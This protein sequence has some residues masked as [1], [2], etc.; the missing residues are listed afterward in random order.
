MKQLLIFF[1]VLFSAESIAQDS[2]NINVE[3]PKIVANLANGASY[4]Y[5]DVTIKFLKVVTDSRCPKDVQCVW[6][7]KA[8][9][10]VSITKNAKYGSEEEIKTI[11]IPPYANLQNKLNVIFSSEAFSI[12][13]F[14]L[15]PYP[16]TK[17]KIKAEDYVL[18]LE[19]K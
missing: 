11:T 4:N 17:Q 1:I 5:E 7:G 19:V 8:E 3:T 6:A 13:G 18:K 14:D 16:S 15:L 10:L 9:V 12:K 2:I